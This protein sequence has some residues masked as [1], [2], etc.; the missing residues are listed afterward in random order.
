MLKLIEKLKNLNSI[1]KIQHLHLG[2]YTHGHFYLMHNMNIWTELI[3]TFRGKKRK[4][5]RMR[6]KERQEGK[7]ERRRGRREVEGRK[8]EKEEGG[9]EEKIKMKRKCFAGAKF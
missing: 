6:K 9:E 7:K 8:E 4:K 2:L 5:E 3:E 1:K